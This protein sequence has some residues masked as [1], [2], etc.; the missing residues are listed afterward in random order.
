MK[1]L[2]KTL[3]F[4]LTLALCWLMASPD[5]AIAQRGRGGRD[6]D[7]KD[8]H[9]VNMGGRHD[10]GRHDR[11]SRR[12]RDGNSGFHIDSLGRLVNDYGRPV[13]RDGNRLDAWGRPMMKPNQ[14]YRHNDAV[15]PL[16]DRRRGDL[17]RDRE[18]WGADRPRAGVI[19]SPRSD[20]TVWPQASLR[21]SYGLMGEYVRWRGGV[22][23]AWGS[24]IEGVF[25]YVDDHL[26]ASL[27]INPRLTRRDLEMEAVTVIRGYVDTNVT[28]LAVQDGEFFVEYRTQVQ[29]QVASDGQTLVRTMVTEAGA[30]SAISAAAKG[31]TSGTVPM[32]QPEAA[33]PQ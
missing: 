9:S 14:K 13:D 20:L 12:D 24:G 18:V 23:G 33:P 10:R 19:V 3:A 16:D 6:D 17:F 26:R 5:F 4:A 31:G 2:I 8:R 1:K 27:R 30:E 21:F 11:G 15:Y 29:G 7:D 22:R 25:S 28:S 32:P